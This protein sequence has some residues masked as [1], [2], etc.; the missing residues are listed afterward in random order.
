ML[1]NTSLSYSVMVFSDIRLL[2]GYPD[3]KP[4]HTMWD[5]RCPR[6]ELSN[7][8]AASNIVQH[9]CDSTHGQSGSPM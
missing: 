8:D 3:D 1:R 4:L 7:A 5:T 2:V 6:A 9:N